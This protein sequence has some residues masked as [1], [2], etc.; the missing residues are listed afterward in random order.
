[1]SAHPAARSWAEA[2]RLPLA[3]LAGAALVAAVLW[4]DLDAAQR[5]VLAQILHGERLAMV[6]VL[7]LGSLAWLGWMQYRSRAAWR[8]AVAQLAEGTVLIAASNPA[9]RLARPARH[10]A[11][12]ELDALAAAVNDL[13]QERARL[14]GEAQEAAGRA[15]AG[16]ELERNR[17]AALIAELEQS[18]LVCNREGRILLYNAAVQRLFASGDGA[19]APVG[20]GR[21][22]FGLIDR[23][24]IQHAFESIEGQA[25]RGERGGAQFVAA[26]AD[27]RLLRV[28]F[29]PVFGNADAAAPGGRL[30]AG[31][32]LLL[33]DVTELVDSDAR[34]VRL[35]QDLVEHSRR[36]T[37]SIRAAIETMIADPDL[38][39]PRRDHFAQIVQAEAVR[40]SERLDTLGADVAA[41][42]HQR[43]PLE[44]MR[45]AD[46]LALAC[47]RIARRPGLAAR[48]ESADAELWLRADSF[49]L[50]QALCSLA[51]RLQEE[52]AVREVV[53]R[54]QAVDEHARLD[55][56]WKGVP[57]SSETAFSWQN[58]AYTLG[59]EESPLSLAQVMERHAGEV[60]YQRDAPTQ[61]NFF[62]LRLP[63]C[64]ARDALRVTATAA[65]RPEFYDFDLFHPGAEAEALDSRRLLELTYTVF[66]T[67]TTGLDPN[68]G[69]EI[70]AIGAVR[71][72]RGRL[73]KSET[74]ETLVD[75]RRSVPA[76]SF[77]VHGIT[78][79]ALHGQP[80]IEQA[81]PRFWRFAEDTV[82]VGHNAAFDMRFLQ[83][84]EEP[85]G[86]RFRQP[87]LDTLL[88]AAIVHPSEAS[89]ALEAIATRLGVAVIGRHTALGDALATAEVFLGLLPLL[90]ARGIH[91]LG[92]ARAA[93][94]KTYYARL[95]Y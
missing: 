58:D 45:G 4:A 60:W 33:A 72:V 29:A 49:T 32:V 42:L 62:R 93:S 40:L 35:F 94:E 36:A 55:L 64:A 7:L 71:I 65:E 39:A 21:S 83:L 75:P 67:E 16:V 27:G 51:G 50:V 79:E 18:V 15:R 3:I 28:N 92:E 54:L 81:L 24:L 90:A 23:D 88:L 66:D 61:T 30:L 31:F 43:W 1:M 26:A 85:T 80:R 44:Q 17:F 5:A 25:A 48:I 87:V 56:A 41:R 76:A 34:S 84:K 14:L 53:F 57:M 68:R 91:T 82:L 12:R 38:D 47:R 11:A 86:V 70:I 59:G 63:R 52:F 6:L 20:L 22:V 77:E 13:A 95:K 9:H 89:Q 19:G 73:L 78:T 46:L 8:G 74:F 10:G 37:A 69:D 2:A